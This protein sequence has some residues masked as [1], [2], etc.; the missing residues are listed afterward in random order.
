MWADA[1]PHPF[2]GEHTQS[3]GYL[4][5]GVIRDAFAGG[6]GLVFGGPWCGIERVAPLLFVANFGDLMLGGYDRVMK[7]SDELVFEWRTMG[8]VSQNSVH[9]IELSNAPI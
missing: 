1:E 2:P 3:A 7:G 4:G 5:R 9:L 8:F 6:K